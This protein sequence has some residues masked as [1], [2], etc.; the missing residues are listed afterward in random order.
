MQTTADDIQPPSQGAKSK[1][2]S[3]EPELEVSQ[4]QAALQS[5]L[6]QAPEEKS[7]ANP[8]NPVPTSEEIAKASAEILSENPT[9]P[10]QS[11]ESEPQESNQNN[12]PFRDKTEEATEPNKPDDMIEELLAEQPMD[13]QDDDDKLPDNAG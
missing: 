1:P 3:H 6:N 7:Q 11:Q 2:E 13:P 12:D 5:T 4:I 8:D 9:Q 10:S